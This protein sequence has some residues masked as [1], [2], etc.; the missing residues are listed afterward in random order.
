MASIELWFTLGTAGMALGTLVLAY[1]LRL[2][3]RSQWRRYSILIAVPG[4]AVVAYALMALD[5]GAVETAVGG[6]AFIPRYVDWLLTTPLHILY[7]GLFA[8]AARGVIGRAVG[9]QTA[10][11]VLGLAGALVAAPLKWVLY[12]GGLVTF[13][14]VVYYAYGDFGEAAERQ[15][16]ATAALYRKL[17]AFLVVLW[18]VYPLIWLVGP[19][20]LV[21]MDVET[22]ALVVTYID[23]VSKVGLGL[24]ALNGQ[25]AFD[26]SAA[27]TGAPGD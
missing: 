10:T 2:L 25:L 16:G 26:D 21:L 27:V 20:S 12:A 19:N 23:I 17:R 14:G 9:L 8:G 1:G 7:L 18:L 15:G 5:V 11:I 6:T 4:I 13:A 3:P 22:T 24:I